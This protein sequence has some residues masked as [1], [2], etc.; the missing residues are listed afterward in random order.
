MSRYD[1]I[2]EAFDKTLE[3]NKNASMGLPLSD[4][5]DII[6]SIIQKLY[7]LPLNGRKIDELFKKQK[8]SRQ[9]E[10]DKNC[11]YIH[12]KIAELNEKSSKSKEEKKKKKKKNSEESNQQQTKQRSGEFVPPKELPPPYDAVNKAQPRRQQRHYNNSNQDNSKLCVEVKVTSNPGQQKK[13][14][15]NPNLSQRNFEHQPA[16]LRGSN[17]QAMHN[18]KSRECNCQDCLREQGAYGY[19][20][21]PVHHQLQN[22]SQPQYPGPNAS[23]PGRSSQEFFSRGY[24][25]YQPPHGDSGRYYYDSYQPRHPNH[26]NQQFENQIPPPRHPNHGNQEFQNNIPPL[27]GPDFYNVSYNQNMGPRGASSTRDQPYR[28]ITHNNQNMSNFNPRDG[29][30]RDQFYRQNDNRHHNPNMRNVRDDHGRTDYHSDAG[31]VSHNAGSGNETQQYGRRQG[32]SSDVGPGRGRGRGRGQNRG[33]SQ[34][35]QPKNNSTEKNN[36]KKKSSSS[37]SSSS[38][39]SD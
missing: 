15:K 27:L 20:S 30:R 37:D 25:E 23:L 18:F 9:Y 17:L 10:Y 3:Y 14:T 19:S 12:P 13:Y 8:S 36:K 28:E 7:K 29:S 11:E 4:S 39:D 31:Y 2:K 1:E 33:K 34:G 32:Y 35:R 5:P 6:L 38:N 24:S 16:H 26:G 22:H 21:N